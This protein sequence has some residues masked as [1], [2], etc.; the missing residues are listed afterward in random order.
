MVRRRQV[1]AG[2][3]AV[4]RS[5]RLVG[6]RNENLAAGCETPTASVNCRSMGGGKIVRGSLSYL[7]RGRRGGSKQR[8]K[9]QF[10]EG[11]RMSWSRLGKKG[12]GEN[13]CLWESHTPKKD[14][15]R[16]EEEKK[17]GRK[18]RIQGKKR[19]GARK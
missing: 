8:K 5:K 2:G 7:E 1:E 11:W 16:K 13:P 6:Q 9:E 4:A 12:G 10:M 3:I 19:G 14:I 15:E 17:G 18:V